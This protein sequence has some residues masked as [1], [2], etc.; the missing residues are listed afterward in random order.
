MLRNLLNKFSTLFSQT[1]DRVRL[2]GF[3]NALD[4]ILKYKIVVLSAIALTILLAITLIQSQTQQTTKQRAGNE[5]EVSISV[6]ST[7]NFGINETFTTS[8]ILYNSSS[9]DISAVDLKVHYDPSILELVSFNPS[10][11]T[12]LIPVTMTTD[13]P[14]ILSYLAINPLEQPI[15]GPMIELG[16]L[17]FKG[18]ALG[19]SDVLFERIQ[20]TASGTDNPLTN[21]PA[22]NITGKYTVEDAVDTPT[23]TPSRLQIIGTVWDQSSNP[24]PAAIKVTSNEPKSIVYGTDA[25]GY[26]NTGQ[27][28]RINDSITIEVVPTNSDCAR[29]TE[30]FTITSDTTKNFDVICVAEPTP[31]NTP[32]PTPTP[33]IAPASCPAA[34][35]LKLGKFMIYGKVEGPTGASVT[36]SGHILD[37]RSTDSCGMYYFS[38]L[39]PSNY[40]VTSGGNSQSVSQLTQNTRID[41]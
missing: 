39:E 4:K 28:W 12:N 24:I 8:L 37:S 16:T 38:N 29:P 11:G 21:N 25:G 2:G 34:P 32:A 30:T 14:G 17:T 36:L 41:F 20:I 6:D 23:P 10:A 9:K 31:T 26:Y 40:N 33:T 1:I 18:K 3:G 15:N 27:Q 22:Q 7:K 5:G 19:T 35:S 13:I